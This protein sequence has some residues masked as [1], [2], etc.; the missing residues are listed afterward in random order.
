MEG[1]EYASARI[2]RASIF[3]IIGSKCTSSKI[4]LEVWKQS[5]LIILP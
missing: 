2:P 3:L 5:E 1:G 4:E